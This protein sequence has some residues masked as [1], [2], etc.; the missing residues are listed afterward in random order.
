MANKNKCKYKYK[1]GDIKKL[2]SLFC[3]LKIKFPSLSDFDVFYQTLIVK[4]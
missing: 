3:D 2:V 4:E 1:M